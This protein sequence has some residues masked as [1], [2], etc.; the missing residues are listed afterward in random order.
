MS[1][2]YCNNCQNLFLRDD[3]VTVVEKHGERHWACPFCGSDDLTET[4][5]CIVCGVPDPPVDLSNG[6]CINCLWDAIDY[7]IGLEYLTE[8]GQ[9]AAF[10]LHGW[11]H[12]G[13]EIKYSSTRLDAHFR[14]LYKNLAE[15]ETQ[16]F[17]LTGDERQF[18]NSVRY[19]LIPYYPNWDTDASSFAEWYTDRLARQKRQA[20]NG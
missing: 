7:D 5:E 19:W 13:V 6:I 15:S 16:L 1:Q 9:I 8:S 20:R 14:S 10:F 3:T 4:E 12:A 11:F 18:L 2:I 17:K